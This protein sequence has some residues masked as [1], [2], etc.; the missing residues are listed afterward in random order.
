MADIKQMLPEQQ[1]AIDSIKNTVVAAGAGSGKT[2]VLSLRY[3]N[4][5]KKYKYN[6]EQILTLTFTKKATVEMSSRIYNVL[7]KEAP[8]QAANFYKANI[9]TLDSYCNSVAKLGCRFYGI[10]PDFVQDDETIKTQVKAKA[11]PFLLEHRDN[12]TLKEFI[13]VQD[14]E[15]VAD[16]L[17]VEPVLAHSKIANPI[18]FRADFKK[19]FAKIVQEW[20]KAVHKISEILSEIES[21]EDE[22][23]G[24]RESKSFEAY[25]KEKNKNISPEIVEITDENIE[26]QNF[27]LIKEYAEKINGIN[28]SKPRVKSEEVDLLKEN[29]DLFR[30]AKSDLLSLAN[31]IYG[32]PYLEKILPL[33]E[34]FQEIV[35]NVKRSSNCLTFA[36]VSNMALQILCDYPEI[37]AMEKEKYKAIMIDEFQDNNLDQRNMLFLLAE[38]KERMEKGVPSVEELEKEKLFFVGD[39][40]Q[41]IYRFRGADVEVFNNLAKDFSDG[42]LQMYTNHRS[43]PKL[44]SAFN[45]IFGGDL[46]SDKNAKNVEFAV[47]PPSVFFNERQQKNNYEIPPYEAIYHSVLPDEKK[48]EIEEKNENSKRR[49]NLAFYEK[50]T[51]AP[52]GFFTGTFAEAEWVAQKIAEKHSEG[53]DFSDMAILLR[54]YSKQAVFERAFLRHGIP[55]NTETLKGFFSDGPVSDIAAYLKLCAYSD[56][57]MA[58]GKVLSSPFVNLTVTETEAVLSLKQDVFSDESAEILQEDSLIRFKN[59]AKFYEEVKKFA[60]ENSLTKTVSKLWYEFGYRFETMWNETVKMYEKL[61]DL[62]FALAREGDEKNLNL[63]S[64][65]DYLFEYEEEN[66]KLEINVPVEKSEGVH[67]MT[68]HKS[69]GLEFKIVFICDTQRG[70]VNEKSTVPVYYS[71]KFGFALNTP[72]YFKD[73]K[74]YFYILAKNENELKE[75]AEM[76]RLTYVALTRAEDEIFITNSSYEVPKDVEEYLPGG[77]KNADSIYKVLAPVIDFYSKKDESGNSNYQD[78]SPF[79]KIEIIEPFSQVEIFSEQKRPNTQKAKIDFVKAL[80]KQSP[81]E[82]SQIIKKDLV[83]KIYVSPSKLYE[84]AEK[85][86]FKKSLENKNRTDLPFAEINEIIERHKNF[87]FNNFGTIA[88][89]YLETALKFYGQEIKVPY[90]NQDVSGLENS[91]GDIKKVEKI[92]EQMTK[93]FLNSELGKKALSSI[94]RKEEFEFKSRFGE[95]ILSGIIDLVFKEK[96]GSFFV[97]DYKTNREIRPEIYYSQLACYRRAVSQMLSVPEEKIRTFLFYLRFGKEIEVLPENLCLSESIYEY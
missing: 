35:M 4:L 3:L 68:V 25:L 42:T 78:A 64:F 79:S 29:I 52:N 27:S 62:L 72:A 17:F 87:D 44:I 82:S 34:E 96:D 15:A 81:Y 12:E 41:S 10:S 39:E 85:D 24:N 1:K 28:Y 16:K 40:K 47:T 38:K 95:K 89:S 9:K 60:K 43:N 76:R 67:I 63:A 49:V 69:K 18:D 6:V 50:N 92:C 32:I 2:T 84:E 71:S 30:S 55:Y 73:S 61:Y 77:T 22:F 74:N 65:V 37:R 20:N 57:R 8:E 14:Y 26:A 70:S 33:L 86:E 66:S 97:V 93:E 21:F 59:A 7:K 23:S 90:N 58:Y 94:W 48:L 88:H 31:Y 46:Y 53:Y 54:S 80:S 91:T 5:I 75:C 45:T 11:L 83:E 13:K 56:D 51:E 36:D 19:Q